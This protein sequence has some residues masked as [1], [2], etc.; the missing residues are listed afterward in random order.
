MAY[1]NQLRKTK[2]KGFGSLL[3]A[4]EDGRDPGSF[5]MVWLPYRQYTWWWSSYIIVFILHKAVLFSPCMTSTHIIIYEWTKGVQVP[6][7]L[8]ILQFREV[9]RHYWTLQFTRVF[10]SSNVGVHNQ[11]FPASKSLYIYSV[12][13]GLMIDLVTFANERC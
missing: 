13:M 10:M 6:M 3:F 2:M 5:S 7:D 4:S 12:T 11:T 9:E 8:P 1:R